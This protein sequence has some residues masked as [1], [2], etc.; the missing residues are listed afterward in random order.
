MAYWVLQKL[1]SREI[2]EIT[3][4]GNSNDIEAISIA[5]FV[6]ALYNPNFCSRRPVSLR[7]NIFVFSISMIL[8]NFHAA[9]HTC[10]NMMGYD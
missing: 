10:R 3:L 7:K 9:R 5:L 4:F 1:T 8:P 2:L 6:E